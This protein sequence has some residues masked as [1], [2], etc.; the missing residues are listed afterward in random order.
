MTEGKTYVGSQDQFSAFPVHCRVG[1]HVH[2]CP[3]PGLHLLIMRLNNSA[4]LS[5][6][7]SERLGIEKFQKNSTITVQIID[8]KIKVDKGREKFHTSIG[9]SKT[10]SGYFGR[11]KPKYIVSVRMGDAGCGVW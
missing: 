2:V 4:R 8:K 10:G 9:P 3:L 11:M 5:G 7:L 6:L 1:I